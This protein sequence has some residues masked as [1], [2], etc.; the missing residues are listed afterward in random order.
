MA[1][2]DNQPKA[3][4]VN[5]LSE[6]ISAIK[7]GTPT[8]T[9]DTSTHGFVLSQPRVGQMVSPRDFGRPWSPVG[10]VPAAPVAAQPPAGTTPPGPTAADDARRAAQATLNTEALVNTMLVVTDDGTTETFGGGG[11]HLTSAYKD[12]LDSMEAPP[13][14]ERPK[15]VQDRIDAARKVLWNDDGTAT[16][17][18]ARYSANQK[19]YAKAI[20]DFTVANIRFLSDPSQV[21]FAQQLL[22]PFQQDVDQA[23]H[24]WRDQGA[25][26]VEAARATI[27]SVGVPLGQGAIANARV[28][29]ENWNMQILGVPAKQPFSYV[30]PSDWALTESQVDDIG[31]TELT[32]NTQDYMNHFEQHGFDVHTADWRGNSESSSGSAGV[33]IFG[34]GFNGSYSEAHTDSSTETTH[35]ASD[36][37]QFHNDA[38]N[39]SVRLEYGLCTIAR[40]WLLTDL[41][42]LDNWFLRG[43]KAGVISSG[44]VNDQLH[45]GK[46]LLP[47]IPISFLAIRNV[48]ISA[49]H[50]NSD[51]QVLSTL[52][53]R[54][55]SHSEE[56]SSTVSGGVEVPVL[57]PICLDFGAS[58]S[59]SGFSGGFTDEHGS[60]FTNDYKS[61]FDG[62]TLSIK[63]AQIVAWLSEV[64]PLSPPMDDPALAQQ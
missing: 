25:D 54:F 32:I 12:I 42:H 9:D 51:S 62:T 53:E 26:Q 23:L 7:Q 24:D 63:G 22:A 38:A 3:L 35:T 48:A 17:V 60:S 39:L 46:R 28:L 57:G 6:I 16:P 59:E 50:W 40:P 31:W 20:S 56:H 29:F 52:D 8:R 30:L 13:A 34:F 21:A 43:A 61:H 37:S 1:A 55:K 64:V 36:G 19:K 18:N 47:M 5:L 14:P 58:H 2:P 11:R 45:D 15:E 44:H 10:G 27:E 33:G 41:F 4:V 49:E